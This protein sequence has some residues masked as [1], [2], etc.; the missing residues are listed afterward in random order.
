MST[1]TAYSHDLLDPILPD[2]PG[3]ADMRWTPEWDR[4]REARRADD[5]LEAGKW[6]KKERK[7]ADWRL[8]RELSPALLRERTKDL[9]LALWLTEANIKLQG[10]P[11]LARRIADHPRADGPLLGPGTLPDDGRWSRRPC[12]S[13][14]VAE[15]QAGRF[16]YGNPDHASGRPG[17]GLQLHRSAGRSPGRIGS[18]LPERRRRDQFGQEKSFRSSCCRRPHFPGRC[19]RWLS[20]RQSATATKNSAETS[21]KPTT[22]SKRSKESLMRSSATP[23]R[24]WRPA[25]RRSARSGRQLRISWT[26]NAAMNRTKNPSRSC[27]LPSRQS[28]PVDP[29]LSKVSHGHLP[30]SSCRHQ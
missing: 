21:N 9:Q 4:I 13:V 8:V 22:S 29:P 2:L 20:K 24:I 11:G 27:P 28:S 10:F 6:T 14:R 16:H 17:S 19:S 3:G 18:K 12:G 26:K 7:V 15:Q 1:A 30:A 5:D 25:A 23:L